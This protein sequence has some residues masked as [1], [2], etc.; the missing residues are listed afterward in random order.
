MVGGFANKLTYYSNDKSMLFRFFMFTE[1]R[2]GLKYDF[3]A[4]VNVNDLYENSDENSHVGGIRAVVCKVYY[5]CNSTDTASYFGLLF[6]NTYIP[7]K[8][9]HNNFRYIELK[10]NNANFTP[11]E[12][13]CCG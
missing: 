3:L 12:I 11:C 5:E 4:H 13:V 7:F 8:T 6:T 10:Y 9:Q 1:R 2:D